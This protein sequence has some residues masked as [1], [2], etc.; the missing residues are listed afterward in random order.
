MDVVIR[1]TDE[2]KDTLKN[3][4]NR[5]RDVNKVPADEK[6]LENHRKMLKVFAFL[7]GKQFL[8]EAASCFLFQSDASLVDR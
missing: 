2:A 4:E 3:Y 7:G 8:S 6:E 5:L 1:N